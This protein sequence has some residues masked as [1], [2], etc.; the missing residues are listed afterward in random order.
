MNFMIQIR[1]RNVYQV[2]QTKLN[3][4]I[5]K[6]KSVLKN[7]YIF[8]ATTN[9]HTHRSIDHHLMCIIDLKIVLLGD[10]TMGE[11]FHDIAIILSG[12]RAIF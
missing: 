7:T 5:K 9:T 11:T 10:S 6:K 4:Q 2:M 1:Q 12:V 8:H 3:K